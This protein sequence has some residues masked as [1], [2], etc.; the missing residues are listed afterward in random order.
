MRQAEPSPVTATI[1]KP[2]R[3]G[4][5]RRCGEWL[6]SQRHFHVKL[7]SGTAAGVTVIVL[8]A[9]IFLYVTI[10]NHQQ[11]SLRAHTIEVIRLSS[12][13]ENDIAA[14]ET[15][16]RGFLLTGKKDYTL[17]FDR[18][19]EMIKR[20]IEELNALIFDNP[21]QRKRVVKVQTIVQQW[22]DTVALPEIQSRQAISGSPSPDTTGPSSQPIVLGNSLLDQARAI[23][24]AVQDDEQI[25][26]NQRMLEQEWATQSTQMLDFLP[27]LERSVLEMQKEKR[28]YLLTGETNFLE[29]YKRAVSDFYTYNGYLS[30]LVANSPSQAELLADAR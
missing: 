21:K 18:R 27:K 2:K 23:L 1:D 6:F 3:V 30:I 25:V 12:F 17:A 16:H 10:R 4:F 7:L 15:G 11:E 28:G 5:F 26:L 14:L 20:R 29:S 9:G 13:V 19:R 22:L 24:Q 8:L